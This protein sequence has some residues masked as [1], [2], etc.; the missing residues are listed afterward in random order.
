MGIQNKMPRE[1]AVRV[2]PSPP[3]NDAVIF[4]HFE[5]QSQQSIGHWKPVYTKEILE[6]FPE[7]KREVLRRLVEF[8]SSG[9]TQIIISY[10][11]Q[12][13]VNVRLLPI[14]FGNGCIN[15]DGMVAL[16]NEVLAK[17]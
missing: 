15:V 14:A 5:H 9:P 7:N 16:I 6:K 3:P 4:Q 12:I 13:E 10:E 8:S 17:E 2:G 1:F 11:Q